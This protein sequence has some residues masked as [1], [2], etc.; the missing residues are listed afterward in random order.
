ML[1]VTNK[2]RLGNLYNDV[3]FKVFRDS[4]RKPFFKQ[5][6]DLYLLTKL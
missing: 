3:I 4:E 6:K 1:S 5:L 2:S